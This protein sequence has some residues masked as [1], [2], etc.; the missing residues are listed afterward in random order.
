MLPYSVR[1]VRDLPDYTIEMFML[2]YINY[3][4]MSP[5][6]L[7][8]TRVLDIFGKLAVAGGEARWRPPSMMTKDTS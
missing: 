4:L 6:I 1:F 3:L 2:V 5:R 7:C 8:C